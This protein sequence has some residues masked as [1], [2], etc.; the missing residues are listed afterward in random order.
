MLKNSEVRGKI[1]MKGKMK[2]ALLSLSNV[3]KSFG[4][5]L[6]FS[7][8]SFTVEDGHKIGLVGVNGTGKTT[9]FKII[10]DKLSHDDGEL[11]RAKTVNIGY[12]EQFVCTSPNITLYDEALSIHERLLQ[13]EDEMVQIQND[14]ENNK[15]NIEKLVLKQ[16]AIDE[17]YKALGGYTYKSI[18]RSTL[19]G[20]GFS[21]GDFT[22]EVSK[23]SGGQKTKLMLA[24]ML[25]SKANLL[26]LDEPTNNLDIDAIEWLEEFLINY[27]GSFIVIS[28]D[29]YFLDKVTTETYELENKKLTIYSGNYSK[30][31]KLKEER[32]KTLSRRY[33]NTQKE[34]ER[35]EGIIEQQKTWS[36]ERN[37]KII[38]NKQKMIDRM[39]QTL[40]KPD[41]ELDKLKFKF[42]TVS[43]GNME[44]LL[45]DNLSKT[46]G[47]NKIFENVSLE[48]LKKERVFLLGPNG[49][50]KT[51]LLKIL[52][53]KTSQTSG[54]FKIGNNIKVAYYNQTSEDEYTENKT[55]LKY[56]WDKHIELT[57]T[58]VRKALAMFL[59]KGEDVEKNILDLSGGEKARISLLML[60]LS[61]S[62][63]LVLDEPT[64]HLDI[65]SREALENA[66]MDYDGTLFIV[67][68]DRYFINKL[69]SKVYRIEKNGAKEFKGNYDFYIQNYV[70]KAEE[71]AVQN[72]RKNDYKERK[73]KEAEERKKINA[74]NRLET[75]II[76]LE[77]TIKELQ[78]KSLTDEY[79]KD[80]TKA[81]EIVKV[82]D[83]NKVT[84]ND[85]YEKW[86]NLTCNNGDN[87]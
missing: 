3:S 7:G 72:V 19:I 77:E 2:M 18:T 29:R 39:E 35:I 59:F 62:N 64:N 69:A 33:E 70:K 80:Y 75:Q 60:M 32:N 76:E 20:L 52:Q 47:N 41:A 9:L 49:T 57:Q 24:K 17:E 34:I 50:G 21:E 82:I 6:L 63:F 11:Y 66:L 54:D 61:E 51:T 55:I 22:L 31:L 87:C 78:T 58:E 4:N 13:I 10:Q 14:I 81:M 86:E 74:I 45:V 46:F 25:L 53:G 83:E 79:A 48:V 15:E 37:F 12:V 65:Y 44:V 5:R 56:V 36:Q 67:S 40:E 28:H 27:K 43:G 68:H 38:R 71:I 23:L 8:V 26:L 1:S 73:A 30:Y 16:H 84:L 85:L 42:K